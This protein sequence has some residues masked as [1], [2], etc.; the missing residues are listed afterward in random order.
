MIKIFWLS[1]QSKFFYEFFEQRKIELPSEL[2]GQTLN[3]IKLN[4]SISK[5]LLLPTA[6][7]VCLNFGVEDRVYFVVSEV[8]PHQRYILPMFEFLSL[9]KENNLNQSLKEVGE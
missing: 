1:Q 9:S 6:F 2:L 4:F 8:P 7:K 5:S 3:I